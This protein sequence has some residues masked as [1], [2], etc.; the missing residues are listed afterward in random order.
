[1]PFETELKKLGL[2]D[3]EAA[4]YQASLE[5]GEATVQQVAKKA[6]V[7]RATTYLILDSLM[8]MGLVSRYEHDNKTQFIPEAPSQLERLLHRQEEELHSRQ[9]DLSE[10]LPKLQ[11]FMRSSDQRPV[12]RYFSGV[13]GLKTMR[14]EMTRYSTNK[15][16]WYS[17]T[18]IDLLRAVFGDEV[19]GQY[20]YAGT[21]AAKGIRH[22][23][24]FTTSSE[25]LRKQRLTT[26]ED[27]RAERRFVP[28]ERFRSSSGMTIFRDR[29]AIATFTGQVGGVVIES[30]SAADMMKEFFLLVWDSLE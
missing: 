20:T 19:R 5:L 2:S 8:K 3:K 23:V 12:V 27:E 16:V 1:M 30:Q 28:P 14:A 15:D 4:V 17:F 7:A 26:A 6:Q 22:K 21:R 11:A 29:I 10:L 13:E 18:P 25:S 24:I 9:A